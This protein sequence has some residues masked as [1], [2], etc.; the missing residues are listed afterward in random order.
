MVIKI[1]QIQQKRLCE[2]IHFHLPMKICSSIFL[3]SKVWSKSDYPASGRR[4]PSRR[5]YNWSTS[6]I[7]LD[8][9]VSMGIQAGWIWLIIFFDNLHF[10]VDGR[11]ESNSPIL[12]QSA[13]VGVSPWQAVE[14]VATLVMVFVLSDVRSLLPLLLLQK[15]TN[16]D[17]DRDR[18][19]QMTR[20][21]YIWFTTK[22]WSEQDF[23]RF[24]WSPPPAAEALAAGR[25]ADL[26][27]VE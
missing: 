21:V 15:S 1:H 7:H 12:S 23:F 19:I 8:F 22:R 24:G 13:H 5:T 27:H 11:S 25:A 16:L 4:L 6:L 10:R 18:I 26:R 20:M 2:F 17:M 3:P 9:G 14:S